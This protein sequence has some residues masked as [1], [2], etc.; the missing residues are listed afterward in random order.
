M[1]GEGKDCSTGVIMAITKHNESAS[2]IYARKV[3]PLSCDGVGPIFQLQ[4]RKG[5][6]WDNDDVTSENLSVG[7]LMA[8]KSYELKDDGDHTNVYLRTTDRK[9]LVR[10]LKRKLISLSRRFCCM[11]P[12]A[13][14]AQIFD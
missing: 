7:S 2:E 8:Y 14:I 4:H 5:L 9:P 12:I 3:D 1:I 11:A 10:K 13:Q 6:L